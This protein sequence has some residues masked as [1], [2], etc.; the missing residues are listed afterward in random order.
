MKNGSKAAKSPSS[1]TI[2]T[3]RSATFA[4]ASINWLH[5]EWEPIKFKIHPPLAVASI[6]CGHRRRETNR[7]Q[8]PHLKIRRRPCLDIFQN[9]SARKVFLLLKFGSW[10]AFSNLYKYIKFKTCQWCDSEVATQNTNINMNFAFGLIAS[11]PLFL[12]SNTRA[13]WKYGLE[14]L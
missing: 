6:Y 14:V 7:A 11:S 3:F 1:S 12:F 5:F 8:S 4:K 9:Q 13:N 2:Q 10:T